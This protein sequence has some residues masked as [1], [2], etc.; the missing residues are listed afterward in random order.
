MKEEGKVGKGPRRENVDLSSCRERDRSL[1]RERERQAPVLSICTYT[2]IGKTLAAYLHEG[3]A[4]AAVF[5]RSFFPSPGE[6]KLREKEIIHSS[7][8]LVMS[9]CVCMCVYVTA[10]HVILRETRTLTQKISTRA[11]ACVRLYLGVYV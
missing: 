4:K 2:H 9:G 8:H 6:L 1:E 3:T 10:L 11:D 5:V 7:R